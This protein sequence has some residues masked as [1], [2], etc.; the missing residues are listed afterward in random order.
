[1]I[2]IKSTTG[3]SDFEVF[4]VDGAQQGKLGIDKISIVVDVPKDQLVHYAEYGKELNLMIKAGFPMH[5]DTR[6]KK[7][8][9]R[10]SLRFKISGVQ[11]TQR[12][13]LQF[14]PYQEE[15]GF[16]RLE[17][18]PNRLEAKGVA[19]L[20]T[21]LDLVTPH[22]WPS[23]LEWGKVTRV[24]ASLDVPV[25]LD[26][27]IWDSRYA[28]H[29]DRYLSNGRP[30]TVYLGKKENGKSFV[31][32][33]DYNAKHAPDSLQPVTRIERQQ[34]LDAPFS[35]LAVLNNVFHGARLYSWRCPAPDNIPIGTWAMFREQVSRVGLTRALF[36]LQ[37][38]LR[39]STKAHVVKYKSE[40]IDLEA[41]WVVWPAVVDGLGLTK[42]GPHGPNIPFID[43]SV[44]KD[45]L[46]QV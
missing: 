43:A 42:P 22:G 24:D 21:E 38:E 2:T 41:S 16:M 13:L 26:S 18:N 44:P 37:P 10:S 20:K 45:L 31:R 29:R 23:F 5:W 8:G 35:E 7:N 15:N 12:P 11:G 19:E 4:G 14:G 6:V 25:P 32:V 40:L 30:E 17:L 1:M 9:Y 28:V 36:F 39:A 34:K 27:I 33:Y 3:M 46:G